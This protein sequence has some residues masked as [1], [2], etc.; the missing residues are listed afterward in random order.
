MERTNHIIICGEI[1][2]NEMSTCNLRRIKT[3]LFSKMQKILNMLVVGH[4]KETSSVE[5]RFTT[6]S[7]HNYPRKLNNQSKDMHSPVP[8]RFK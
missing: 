3:F 7:S 6:G 2:D 1:K 5:D 4:S 8:S